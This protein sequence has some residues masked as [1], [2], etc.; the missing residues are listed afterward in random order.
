MEDLDVQIGDTET[1]KI[2]VEDVITNVPNVEA[3]LPTRLNRTLSRIELVEHSTSY[4]D[5][6]FSLKFRKGLWLQ[7]GFISES[8]LTTLNFRPE[9]TL[10]LTETIGQHLVA[11]G[12]FE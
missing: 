2:D 1:V 4:S 3:D 12:K 11:V 10:Y 6:S 5:E 7:V 9:I 8:V